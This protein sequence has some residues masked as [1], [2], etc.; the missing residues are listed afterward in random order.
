M[1]SLGPP[2]SAARAVYETLAPALGWHYRD[3]AIA[4]ELS[5]ADHVAALCR[6]RVDAIFL[7]GAQPDN[8]LRAATAA[9]DTAFVPVAGAEVEALDKANP[10]L[11]RAV[12]PAGL[13]KPAPRELP[14][15]GIAMTAVT[16]SKLDARIAYE[17]AK[18]VF[19]N[20][21]RFQRADPVFARL[22][23]KRMTGD[24]LMGAIHEGAARLYKERGLLR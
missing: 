11:L 1:S 2:G 6:G 10:A 4:A 8:A 15:L 24:G 21:Q 3:F 5:P 19:D 22:D 13:Y 12:I 9:C 23:P 20:L 18:L 17:V 16:T 14:T 7:I